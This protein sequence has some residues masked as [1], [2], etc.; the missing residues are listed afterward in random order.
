MPTTAE[1]T[2]GGGWKLCIGKCMP[3]TTYSPVAPDNILNVVWCKCHVSSRRPSSS[4]LCSCHKHG[5]ECVV[6]CKDCHVTD[7]ENVTFDSDMVGLT[8]DE[9]DSSSDLPVEDDD[10]LEFFIPW[11]N[12]ETI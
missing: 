3:V 10:E 8:D 4:I 12:E 6:A 7:C 2:E 5:L 11:V 1:P 9:T